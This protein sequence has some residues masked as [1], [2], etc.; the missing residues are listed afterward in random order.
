MTK[1]SHGDPRRP[2][3]DLVSGLAPA[4]RR[5]EPEGDDFAPKVGWGHDAVYRPEPPDGDD[6][7]EEQLP[8]QEQ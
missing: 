8:E 1:H 3:G 2:D 5:R 7:S 6:A 4:D